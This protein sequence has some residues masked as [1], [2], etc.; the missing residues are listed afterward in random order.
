M[1]STDIV[2]ETQ[3]L[4]SILIVHED[5]RPPVAADRHVIRQVRANPSWCSSHNTPPIVEESSME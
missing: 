3:E 5:R 2:E 4:A 1:A